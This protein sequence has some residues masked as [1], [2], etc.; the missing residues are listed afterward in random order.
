MQVSLSVSV[1][2]NRKVLGMDSQ[3][4]TRMRKE[5]EI[6]ERRLKERK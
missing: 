4:L 2:C 1:A 3:A 6:E 5:M